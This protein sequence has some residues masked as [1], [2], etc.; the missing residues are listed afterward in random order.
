MTF[1]LPSALPLTLPE[2]PGSPEPRLLHQVAYSVSKG[3]LLQLTRCLA[4]DLAKDNV[5][6]TAL[7]PGDT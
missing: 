2:P 7:C 6:C 1:N 4:L 5:R 3:A